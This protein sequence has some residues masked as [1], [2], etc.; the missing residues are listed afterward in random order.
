TAD[1]GL[2]IVINAA[3][4]ITSGPTLAAA[5]VDQEYGPVA[6]DVAG[7]T[8]PLAFDVPAGGLPAGLAL[9]P[10]TGEL[11]GTPTDPG[12]YTFTVVVADGAGAEAELEFTLVVTDELLVTT[13]ELSS[14]TVNTAGYA[15]IL[16]ASGGTA[17][18][19]WSVTGSLPGGLSLDG[20]TG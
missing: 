5:V 15:E 8:A 4:E 6:I 18:Y 9:D 16:A 14:W 20:A 1:A 13:S 11:S 2:D 19:T 17:P 7:G 3:P 12:T 10:A